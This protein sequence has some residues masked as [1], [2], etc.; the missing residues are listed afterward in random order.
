LFDVVDA[1]GFSGGFLGSGKGGEQQR[2]ENRDD[3]DDDQEFD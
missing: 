2:R 3:G 1:L